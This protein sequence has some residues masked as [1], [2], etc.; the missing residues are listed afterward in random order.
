LSASLLHIAEYKRTYIRG[1]HPKKTADKQVPAERHMNA[2][3]P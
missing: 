3:E 2:A 1:C